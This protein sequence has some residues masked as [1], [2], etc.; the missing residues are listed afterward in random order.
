MKTIKIFTFLAISLLLLACGGKNKENSISKLSNNSTT[1]IGAEEDDDYTGDDENRSYKLGKITFTAEG[2]TSTVDNFGLDP[3][4][5]MA[6]F[7]PESDVEPMASV[8]F[9]SVDFKRT[10][11]LI[12]KDFDAMQTNFSGKKTLSGGLPTVNF[13]DGENTYMFTE[14]E[15]VVET[16]SRKT[17]KVKF[18]ATGKCTRSVWGDPSAMKQNMPSTLEVDAFMPFS[19]VDGTTFKTEAAQKFNIQ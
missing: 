4:T 19:N 16:F 12:F 7:T 17:G 8:V 10:L 14:G 6:W 13:T 5:A 9:K 2:K 15:L 1:E 3:Y 11:L 18:K